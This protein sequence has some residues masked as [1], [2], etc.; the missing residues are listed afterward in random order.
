MRARLLLAAIAAVVSFDVLAQVHEP[1]P[2]EELIRQFRAKH[3][4]HD[5]AAMMNAPTTPPSPIPDGFNVAAART[6]NITAKQF[7]YQISPAPFEVNVGDSVTLNLTSTDVIHGFQME[8][9]TESI[10]VRKGDTTSVSFVANTAGSFTFFCTIFCGTGHEGMDGRFTVNASTVPA[11]T[12]TSFTPTTAPATGGTSVTITG[13]NFQ[14]GATVRFGA[15]AA[16]GVTFNS[17]TSLT[18]IAPA[19]AAGSVAITVTNPDGQS[20]NRTGFTYTAVSGV[21]IASVTPSTGA[22]SGK[23]AITVTGSGF[24]AGAQL[25]VG[26]RPATGLTITPTSITASTPLGS[27]DFANSS[28]V[29]VEVKNPDGT[30]AISEKAFTYTVPA[31]AIERISTPTAS[32]SGGTTLTITGRGFTSALPVTVS[33]GGLAATEVKVV[34]AV[35]LSA[36][37]PARAAGAADVVVSVGTQSATAASALMYRTAPARRRSSRP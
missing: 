36:I 9:Y 28:V 22:T 21:T 16:S 8:R 18:A 30:G 4:G 32:P 37:A 2:V 31:P 29:D 17:A 1:T 15:A 3:A 33:I 25:L 34:N 13:T 6:F 19:Q 10:T 26:G 35:T 14:Q 23:D 11:P 27:S 12:V 20:A 24:L 7:E 5:H